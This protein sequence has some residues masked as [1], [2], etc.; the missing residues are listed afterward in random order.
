M[1]ESGRCAASAAP[2]ASPTLDSR[3]EDTTAGSP[4]ASMI[5]AAARIP[6]SGCAFTTMTSAAPRAATLSGSETL[7]IDSSAAI[8]TGRR[9]MDTHSRSRASPWTSGTGCSTYWSGP[10][11]ASAVRAVFASSWVY[12]PFASQR[13]AASGSARRTAA[14]RARSSSSDAIPRSAIFTLTALTPG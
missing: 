5:D 9:A 8:G 10:V 13:T 3:A 14:T 12:A 11:R 4:A 2:A 7:R 6:P 1:L